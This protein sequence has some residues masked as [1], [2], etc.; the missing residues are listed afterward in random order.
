MELYQ[1]L[2]I[3][4]R[5]KK[6]IR[7]LI[8]TGATRT[9][10]RPDV[11]KQIG[12]VLKGKDAIELGEKGKTMIVR[13]GWFNI[14]IRNISMPVEGVVCDIRPQLVIGVDVLQRR[15]VTLDFEKHRIKTGKIKRMK[16][17]RL[18]KRRGLYI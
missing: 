3:E 11:A 8:D 15:N 12:I 5:R 2:V 17:K 4:G 10:V 18:S 16:I 1:S 9:Y 7:A 14:I 6:R 13:Y